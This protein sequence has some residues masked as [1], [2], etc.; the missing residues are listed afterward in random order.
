MTATCSPP[1]RCD[2]ANCRTTLPCAI[3]PPFN[4]Q[5]WM[6]ASGD[7]NPKCLSILAAPIVFEETRGGVVPFWTRAEFSSAQ[8][9]LLEPYGLVTSHQY[10]YASSPPTFFWVFHT[11]LC[12]QIQMAMLCFVVWGCAELVSIAHSTP[13]QVRYFSCLYLL[14]QRETGR[15]S[16]YTTRP[17]MSNCYHGSSSDRFQSKKHVKYVMWTQAS[18]VRHAGAQRHVCCCVQIFCCCCCTHVY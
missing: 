10:N 11:R 14:S 5:L 9:F 4:F 7:A 8:F 2:L 16:T 1:P 3:Q 6:S 15:N 17:T 12:V 13:L 18:A